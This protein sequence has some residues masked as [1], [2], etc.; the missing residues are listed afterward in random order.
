MNNGNSELAV[1]SFKINLKKL[2]T[3]YPVK[4]V[5]MHGSSMS[6]FDN[7]IIWKYLNFKDL[8]LLGE[9]YLSIDFSNVVYLSDTARKWNGHKFSLR[10]KTSSSQYPQFIKTNDIIEA[11]RQHK[12]HQQVLLLTHTLWTDKI[13]SWIW[14]EVREIIRN[15]LK[16]I[17]LK[18]PFLRKI[19]YRRIKKFST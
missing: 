18:I 7:R 5:C 11:I 13:F 15:N 1:A 16:R 4:T 9:P 2:R 17:I 10:D 12:I 6:E 19:I 8:N 3:F 14:L